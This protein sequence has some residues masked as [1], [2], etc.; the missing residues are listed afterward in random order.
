MLKIGLTGG[1]ACGK[2]T[3]SDLFA[4]YDVPIIDA[5]VVAHALVQPGQRGL[6]GIVA[7][8]GD[9]ILHNDGTLNRAKLRAI[10]FADVVQRRGLENLLHPLIRQAM[11]QQLTDLPVETPYCVLSIPLLLETQQTDWVDRVL[12]V[13]CNEAQQHARLALRSGLSAV[14]IEQMLAA[15][16]SR[17]ARLAAAHDVIDNSGDVQMLSVRV[18]QLHQYYTNIAS[19]PTQS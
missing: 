19:T 11:Q 17:Q 6:Q 7:R 16:V 9:E 3:V 18:A 13:D 2:T 1:I 10:V 8:F 5:D 15:Q 4:G 14:E 12:V